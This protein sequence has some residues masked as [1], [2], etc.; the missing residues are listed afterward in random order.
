MGNLTTRKGVETAIAAVARLRT[1]FP[2]VVLDIIGAP[3]DPVYAARLRAQA[4]PLAGAVRFLAP[5]TQAGI[6]L[7][8]DR[9]QV[10]VLTSREEHTPV[11]VAEAMASGRP[12]VATDVG[13]LSGMV[14]SGE[15]GYLVPAGNAEAVAEAIATLLSD[16]VHAAKLGAEAARRAQ[17]RFHPT[18]VA[19]AYL[20]AL[21]AAMEA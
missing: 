15:T 17:V 1:T 5:T 19:S 12:V 21:R 4:D 8:L 14:T 20:T 16:S 9:A 13:A 10:L 7:A 18:V 6:K 3:V 2:G 11:I